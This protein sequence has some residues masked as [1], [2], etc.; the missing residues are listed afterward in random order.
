VG[1]GLGVRGLRTEHLATGRRGRP[2]E[3]QRD[4]QDPDSENHPNFPRIFTCGPLSDPGPVSTHL[5]RT[6]SPLRRGPDRPNALS[7]QDKSIPAEVQRPASP[8]GGSVPHL[9]PERGSTGPGAAVREGE[10][11]VTKGGKGVKSGEI[12][13]IHFPLSRI[14]S[15]EVAYVAGVSRAGRKRPFSCSASVWRRA[16]L[17]SGQESRRARQ[18]DGTFAVATVG[19]RTS[20]DRESAGGRDATGGGDH[21]PEPVGEDSIFPRSGS[22]RAWKLH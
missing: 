1:N 12:S 21:G 11:G 7:K 8:R 9:S 6:Q 3:Q 10:S 18:A 16:R 15:G 2:E 14:E 17:R 4:Q 13:A 22:R 5:E 19:M 20:G